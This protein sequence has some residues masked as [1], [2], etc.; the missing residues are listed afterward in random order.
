MFRLAYV[1]LGGILSRV[2]LGRPEKTYNHGEIV[3]WLQGVL[4]SKNSRRLADCR[5]HRS[6]G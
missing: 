4:D 1:G 5:L 2:S 3:A 6:M